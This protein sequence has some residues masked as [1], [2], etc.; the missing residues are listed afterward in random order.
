MPDS[1]GEKCLQAI[2]TALDGAG[3]PA[4]SVVHRFRTLAIDSDQLPAFVVYAI[5]ES[6]ERAGTRKGLVAGHSMTVAI[7][8]RVTNDEPDVALDPL[9]AWAVAAIL[10]DATLGGYAMDVQHTGT[11]WAAVTEDKT[12]GAARIDFA[13]HYRTRA[14][15]LTTRV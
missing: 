5:E 12:Y 6:V 1:I 10:A 8:A 14:A 3:K 11:H 4:G 9:I 13:V 7:E 15:D 2:V